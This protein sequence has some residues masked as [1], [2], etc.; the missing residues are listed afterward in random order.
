M[1]YLIYWITMAKNILLITNSCVPSNNS[2]QLTREGY[3]IDMVNNTDVNLNQVDAGNYDIIIIQAGRET[4]EWQLL[5]QIRRFAGLPL[6]VISTYASADI[7]AKAIDA[8][9]DYFLRKPFGP[10]ELNARI[11]S[12]LQH[13]SPRTATP[14]VV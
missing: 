8:G 3:K 12:L 11:H 5:E 13:K 10:M 14:V 2:G 7:S 9:A 6:I 1:Y 4:E